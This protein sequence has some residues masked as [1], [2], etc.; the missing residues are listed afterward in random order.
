V[1]DASAYTA[2]QDASAYTAV[3]RGGV[4]CIVLIVE[5]APQADIRSK[6]KA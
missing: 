5:I 6:W 3:H 4:Q 1:Q 2:V